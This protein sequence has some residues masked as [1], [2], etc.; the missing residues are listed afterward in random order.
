MDISEIMAMTDH[1][2]IKAIMNDLIK[3]KHELKQELMEAEHYTKDLNKELQITE[4]RLNTFGSRLNE[5]AKKDQFID[6][7]IEEVKKSGQFE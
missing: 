1:K 2:E 4:I 7:L 6:P 5:L 3:D